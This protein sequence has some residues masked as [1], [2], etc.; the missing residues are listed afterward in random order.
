MMPAL[1]N[2]FTLRNL[3]AAAIFT[4]VVCIATVVLKVDI[5]QTQG[6]FNIGDSMVYVSALLFGPF[7]GAFAGG[8]GS[9]LGDLILQAPWYAPGT[10]VIKGIEGWLVGYVSFRS[11]PL[12]KWERFWRLFTVFL[13][14]SLGYTIYMLGSVYYS[15]EWQ[16]TP[17]GV[18]VG[19]VQLDPTFW[20][21]VALLLEALIV[22][23]GV[24][25]DRRVAWYGVAIIVG[26]AEMILGYFLYEFYVLNYGYA[27][28]YEI[29][30][31]IG[32]T[33][34]GL[35]LAIPI[36]K[37]VRKTIRLPISST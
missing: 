1:S 16:F 5:P 32:Q 29:P 11:N 25:L 9:M 4:A 12:E 31:N 27:A 23:V 20:I 6:Y 18:N 36:V 15:V 10:I 22:Y 2:Q 3:S 13:G 21:I 34:V 26:G 24:R 37:T 28:L 35:A 17:F 8:V 33:I 30:F 7:V 14:I 19:T